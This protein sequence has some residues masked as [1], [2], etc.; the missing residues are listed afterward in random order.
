[1]FGSKLLPGQE[2]AQEVGSCYRLDFL[3]QAVKRVTMNACEET[4]SRP[5][6]NFAAGCELAANYKTLGLELK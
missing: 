5:L 2:I 1:M 4:A 6:G 3:P